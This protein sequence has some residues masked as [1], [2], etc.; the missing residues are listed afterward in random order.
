MGGW[1]SGAVGVVVLCGYIRVWLYGYVCG[2]VWDMDVLGC[3]SV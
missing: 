2:W 3:V 1:I